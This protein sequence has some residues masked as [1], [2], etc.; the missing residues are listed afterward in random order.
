MELI[1]PRVMIVEDEVLV[2]MMLEEN[3]K[4]LGYDIVA[5]SDRLDDAMSKASN[6]VADIAVLDVNLA[7]KLSYPVAGVL[8]SRGIPF[9]FATGYGTK[10]LP[11]EFSD[12]LV[13]AKPYSQRQLADFLVAAIG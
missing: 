1:K 12:C 11:Q 9:I 5:V 2:S 8:R 7:G 13:L 10:G 4:D 3:L 6:V